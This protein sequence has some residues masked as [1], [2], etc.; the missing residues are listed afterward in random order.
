[1][2]ES[3]NIV[4]VVKSLRTG[5][6]MVRVSVLSASVLFLMTG[7]AAEQAQAPAPQQQVN[8]T[9]PKENILACAGLPVQGQKCGLALPKL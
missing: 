1:M 2:S 6:N 7:C 4:Y 8:D 5:V 9:Q 3:G